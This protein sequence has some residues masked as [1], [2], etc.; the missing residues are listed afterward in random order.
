MGL[1]GSKMTDEEKRSKELDAAN[2]RDFDVE[3]RKIKLLL[4]G[5]YYRCIGG[6]VGCVTTHTPSPPL[7]VRVRVA[8]PPSSSK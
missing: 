8:S 7:Q 4:L 3:S 5:M 6:C 2:K 1:C